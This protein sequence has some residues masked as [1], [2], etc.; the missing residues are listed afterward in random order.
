MAKSY[1]LRIGRRS[2]AN[3]I[4]LITTVCRDRR[5]Y[6][7]ELHN[8]RCVVKTLMEM[9]PSATTLC[10]VVMP[11]HLHWL[12]Q[13]R[14]GAELS[15]TVKCMKAMTSRR[16][17]LLTPAMGSLWQKGFHDRA[18]RREESLRTVARYIV[19]NPLRGGLVKSLG[20]YPFWDATWL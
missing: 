9:Q 14:P 15:A 7:N 11:D 6:F 13:L 16:M 5:P 12:M 17:K 1:R 18:I 8:A 19:A 3:Q 20:Q 10:Y 2:I 4:Y